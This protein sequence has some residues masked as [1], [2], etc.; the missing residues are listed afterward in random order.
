MPLTLDSK[1][2]DA[3]RN[4]IADRLRA[5]L[6]REQPPLP[7]RLRALVARLGELD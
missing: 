6:A 5:L 3:I 7:A 2:N 4:E 1:S